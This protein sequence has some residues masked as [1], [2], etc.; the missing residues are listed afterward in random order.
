MAESSDVKAL[1][2]IS[3]EV[4]EMQ[5]NI[6]LSSQCIKAQAFLVDKLKKQSERQKELCSFIS[7]ANLKL[8]TEIKLAESEF[9]SLAVALQTIKS[10][11][12]ESK[13]ELLLIKERR[14]EVEERV[15]TGIKKYEDLWLVSKTKYENIPFIK[16]Y[17]EAK[18]KCQTIQESINILKNEYDKLYIYKANKI[19]ELRNLE[20]QRVIKLAE[21][22]IIERPITLKIINE[23][24]NL[25]IKLQAEIQSLL[26]ECK[27]KNETAV[28]ISVMQKSETKI[29]E[30]SQNKWPAL[31]NTSDTE[32][33]MMPHI[34]L[35]SVD[36]DILS[37]KLDKIKRV[38]HSKVIN[39]IDTIVKPDTGMKHRTE[40]FI[41]DEYVSSYFD[42]S[43]KVDIEADDSKQQK[44][45]SDKKLIHILEDI[46]LDK[47]ETYKIVANI[48]PNSLQNVNI[49]KAKIN[50]KTDNA[51]IQK[52]VETKDADANEEQVNLP[53]DNTPSVVLPPT[54][55]MDC[56][57]GNHFEISQPTQ[58]SLN[59]DTRDKTSYKK[60]PSQE[61]KRV[62]FDI[63]ESQCDEIQSSEENK[64]SNISTESF[65]Q[66][67]EMILK[68]HNLDLSPQ[69]VYTKNTFQPKSGKDCVNE[70]IITSKFFEDKVDKDTA[71]ENAE[72]KINQSEVKV[73]E[74]IVSPINEPD[75]DYNRLSKNPQS[76]S[77]PKDG[78]DMTVA[79][80]LF[81][82]GPQSIPDSLNL[83]MSTAE[84]EEGDSDFPHGIDSSLLL[85]PKADEAPSSEENNNETYAQGIPNFLSGLRKTGLSLFGAKPE[86]I[87][88]GSSTENQGNN[89][90]FSFSGEDKRNRGGLFSMFR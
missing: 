3:T 19:S 18:N 82:H 26:H 31:H 33:L 49:I 85:S 60:D 13:K 17:L 42:I 86:D 76:C 11:N 8:K 41:K 63:K 83:S 50:E 77:S 35:Q 12:V 4:D 65:T 81:T 61:S 55:F 22:F 1:E 51:D 28:D 75:A 5:L 46:K 39:K 69:F 90:T 79:G 56:S 20:Q 37:V 44:D 25:R 27:I 57:K 78:Q 62:T 73:T 9:N 84:Y 15:R 74:E 24:E 66:M 21:Y 72:G 6:L 40:E 23:K 80:L 58:E 47:H 38:E 30:S 70:N 71:N 14:F 64:Q 43:S 16:R 89:F 48:N 54:Q 53:L 7:S 32:N 45:F 10:A 68:K 88:P 36:L 34:Q 87:K 2:K 52:N 59:P 29:L 67:K